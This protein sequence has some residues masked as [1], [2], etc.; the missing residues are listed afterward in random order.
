MSLELLSVKLIKV[1]LSI[2]QN[3]I[4]C[5]ISG[6]ADVPMPIPSVEFAA[7]LHQ[8]RQVHVSQL[9]YGTS[10]SMVICT[11]EVYASK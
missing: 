8:V 5:K 9:V 6:N 11:L 2:M 4:Y 7:F 3:S 10:H 1:N